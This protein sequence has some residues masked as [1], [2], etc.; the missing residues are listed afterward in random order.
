MDNHYSQVGE[1]PWSPQTSEYHPGPE[2]HELERE[3][4]YNN[5]KVKKEVLSVSYKSL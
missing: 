4:N 5:I 1:Y 2:E 3:P